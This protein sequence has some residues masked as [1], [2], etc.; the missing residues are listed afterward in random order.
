MK[1]DIP[2]K[3]SEPYLPP[4][5]RKYRYREAEDIISV[6]VEEA[7]E[8]DAPIAFEVDTY[9]EKVILHLYK[10]KLWRA[11]MWN[12]M[13]CGKEGLF[14]LNQLRDTLRYRVCPSRYSREEVVSSIQEAAQCFLLLDGKV[15]RPGSEPRYVVM[16]FGLGHNHGGTSLMVDYFYN[17]NISHKAYFT[18]LQR[19][20]A[21]QAAKETALRRGDTNDAD[22]I[23]TAYNIRVLLPDQVKCNPAAEHGDGDPFLNKLHALTEIAPSVDIAAALVICETLSTDR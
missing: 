5:C 11:V 16:T 4:R 15:Y 19:D 18:A 23:G 21:I 8:T 9:R 14:P 13:C 7:R 20:E 12:E 2:I 10:D 1:F 3:Y 17:S 22:S 6:D